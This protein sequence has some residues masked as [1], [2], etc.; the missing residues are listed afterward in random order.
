MLETKAQL[1]RLRL[2]DLRELAINEGVTFNEGERYLKADIVDLLLAK[3]EVGKSNG[4]VTHEAT[5]TAGETPARRQRK[6]SKVARAPAVREHDTAE[7]AAKSKPTKM[8]RL[9]DSNPTDLSGASKAAKVLGTSKATWVLGTSAVRDGDLNMHLAEIRMHIR[10]I[11]TMYYFGL[12]ASEWIVDNVMAT[13]SHWIFKQIL[14]PALVLLYVPSLFSG[15]HSF[16]IDSI[17]FYIHFVTWW[18]M[19][20]ILSSV[21][22]GTGLHSGMLF[23]FPHIAAVTQTAAL[24]RSTDFSSFGNMWLRDTTET[25]FV[26]NNVVVPNPVNGSSVDPSIPNDDGTATFGAIFLKVVVPAMLWGVGT[27][28][29][30]IPPYAIS[31]A[32]KLAGQLNSDIDDIDAL[33]NPTSFY[34]RMQKW[35]IDFLRQYG[36]WG[37]L[38]MSAWPNAAFDLCGICCGH[39]LMPFWQFFSATLIG[40]G[41]IK[42]NL[43]AIA[44]I[45]L[46]RESTMAYLLQTLRG[47]DMIPSVNVVVDSIEEML[48]GL[49]GKVYGETSDDSKAANENFMKQAWGGVL[50]LFIGYFIV[51]CVEQTA[52]AKFKEQ[53]Q[54]QKAKN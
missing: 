26:C 35:M 7:G 32:A 42:V 10:P 31:R 12:S 19:L 52:Q 37:V 8:S 40:K 44:L 2:N 20:G 47:L 43:Q 45:A 48:D 15:P 9:L 11:S 16:Y 54:Q 1:M 53:K 13:A 36:F 14:L 46:F 25:D 17:I 33:D 38:L 29:G 24:C 18:F 23:L 41:F 6:S 51:S 21:G 34:Q 39:F 50:I 28:V 22:L 30:E 49:K 5:F 3:R 4:T 27:A